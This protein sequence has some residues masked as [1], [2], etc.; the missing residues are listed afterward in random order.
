MNDGSLPF[1]STQRAA[2]SGMR[3]TGLAARCA[4]V[5]AAM[6]IAAGAAFAQ[7]YPSKPVNLMVPYPAGGV[8][9][10]IAR[11]VEKPLGKALG[12]LVIIEN[13]GGVSGALG[14]QK[15]LSAPADGYSLFQGSPNELILAPL[16]LASVKYKS[17]S[18]RLV[19]MIS[20][21]QLAVYTRPDFPAKTMDELIDFA[22]KEAAAGRPLT[23]AS[24]GPGSFYHLM[25]AQLSKVTGIAMTHV[26]YKGGAPANQD[27][28]GGRVDIFITVWAKTY[29]QLAETGKI[30]VLALLNSER[31]KGL[32]QYAAISETK[33]L[34]DFTF[35]LWTGYFVEKDTPQ[36]VVETL[37]KALNQAL[38]EPSV[39]GGIVTLGSEPAK[40]L[41]LQEAA[42]FYA[43]ETARFRAIA[44]GI[45]LEPQ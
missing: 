28:I 45:N 2:A 13:L 4:A 39:H 26:P 20:A 32:E 25:G 37:H 14:A 11:I 3:A 42:K 9:D 19:Q 34:K 21:G 30:K 41:S 7:T 36:A 35:N 5:I 38:A 24:V 29:Q 6:T 1:S 17:D 8:S 40:P 10:T 22:R 33:Q 23:Y 43:D 12:Q 27:L 16:A 18:F 44:K 15:V 31:R